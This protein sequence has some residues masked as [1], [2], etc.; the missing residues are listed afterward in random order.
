MCKFTKEDVLKMAKEQNVKFIRLQFTDIFGIMKNVAIPVSQL[1]KALDGEMMF[2]GSSVE[3]FVRIEESDMYLQPD[4]NTFITF[5]WR[6]GIDGDVGRL[7]CDVY[8]STEGKPFA[9][10]PR[11]V[12]RSLVDKA[13]QKG[14]TLNAGP[15]AEFFLFLTDSEGRPTTIT[16]D[17][18]G[19]FDLSPVDLGEG[20][21]RDMVTTLQKMGYEIEA[22]HHEVAPGQHEIDFQYSD[23]LDIADKIVTFKLVVRSI[24][25]RH[26]LHATFMPKPIQGINGSGMHIN[27]SLFKNGGNTF[28]DP[29]KE[30]GLSDV[31]VNFVGG[32]LKH[33]KAITA[34]TNPTVNSYKRLVPGYEAP[35]NMAW[36]FR[37]RSPLIR[38]P[39]KRGSSTRTEL[40]SPDPSFN[41]YLSLAAI[42]AAGLDGVENQI[43]PPAPVDRNIYDMTEESLEELQID[44]LPETLEKAINHLEEDEL[45]KNA[46]GEHV[47]EKFI[48]AK[49]IEW[50]NY[51]SAVHQWE[52]DEYLTKF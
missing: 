9:G 32:L 44:Q 38:I 42:L 48:E 20:A 28:Y 25:Q 47:C 41:P 1:E 13:V 15:E 52:L 22:S 35:V 33:G 36:S 2:D 16:H 23:A 27:L 14:Y 10:C 7:I 43:D 37:N 40:R 30:N 3:G 18:A 26:G 4:P 21:R 51:M 12:L 31:A 6:S 46:L 8:D 50:K 24:A 17:K 11:S 49:K 29:Q 45:I 19:Y 39:G 34:I 5:P